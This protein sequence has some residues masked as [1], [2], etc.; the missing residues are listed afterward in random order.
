[1]SYLGELPWLLIAG[2]HLFSLIEAA[3]MPREVWPL[4]GYRRTVWLIYLLLLG[5]GMWVAYLLLVRPKLKRAQALI[6]ND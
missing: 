2:L 6:E 1:M 5:W 4:A 3:L